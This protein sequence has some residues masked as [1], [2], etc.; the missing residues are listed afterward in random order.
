MV[1]LLQR[2]LLSTLHPAGL[3][4]G[5]GMVGTGPQLPPSRLLIAAADKGRRW[6]P[7]SPLLPVIAVLAFPKTSSSVVF[8]EALEVLG[9]GMVME[10]GALKTTE[11]GADW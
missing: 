1:R 2:F 5:L 10:C 6:G 4:A 8:S 3:P 11:K 7:S 9:W